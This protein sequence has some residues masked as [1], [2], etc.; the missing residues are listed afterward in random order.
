MK[1]ET[2][3]VS[4]LIFSGVIAVLVIWFAACPTQATAQG[5]QGQDAV[6]SAPGN[7][8]KG[9]PSF[10]DASMFAF[11]GGTLC[12]VI[13]NIL[14]PTGYSAAVIDARGLANSTPPTSMTCAANT[15][16]WSQDNNAHVLNVPSTILLPSTTGS[17]PVVI[18]ATWV[19][20]SKTR[21]VGAGAAIT[22][23]GFTPGTTLQAHS[24]FSGAMIS[25]GQSSICNPCT[26][27]SVER[28]NLRNMGTDGTFT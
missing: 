15:T 5:T 13:Y 9:S 12:S 10:I 27:I 26:G 24:N 7:C 20:P 4:A 18:S 23:A 25:F 22:A 19:M 28:L 6:Y 11:N 21:L 16:P 14:K 3:A 8:C 1:N 17:A 2:K